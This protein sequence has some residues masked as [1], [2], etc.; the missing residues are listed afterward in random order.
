MRARGGGIGSKVRWACLV[1]VALAAPWLLAELALRAVG[2][3]PPDMRTRLA[4]FPRF[5]AFYE[6]DRELGW[7]LKPNL[8]WKGTDVGAPFRTDRHGNRRNPR[9]VAAEVPS[10]V[11]C[12]GDSSTFGFG[13]ADGQT[14]PIALQRLLNADER[15]GR[16]LVRNL[17]VPGYSVVDARIIAERDGHHAPVTLVMVGFI[18][19]FAA[20]R[21]R[22]VSLWMRRAGYACFRSLT[23][24]ALFDWVT[25]R[26]PSAEPPPY[27]VTT[28][29]APDVPEDRYVSELTRTLRSLRDRDSEPIVLVYPPLMA[30]ETV[31]QAVAENFKKPVD[32]VRA[33]VAAHPPYQELTRRV[34][35]AEGVRAVDLE[36]V[37]R[38]AGN[39]AHHLDWVH[40][41]A[42]GLALIAASA[43]DAVRESLPQPSAQRPIAAPAGRRASF[44]P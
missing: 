20:V 8:D 23:C 4:L 28:T 40:P 22:V 15:N 5:P 17:G 2:Y 18:D 41:N 1:A 34:A 29:Y 36:P 7:K 24:S 16:V 44:A 43:L 26:D 9:R 21:Q 35:A 31:I 3:T 30:D 42:A 14:Y 6:P 27:P 33:M 25:W 39:E 10:T 13:S 38:A 19:H 32:V 37:F 12:I 11:D